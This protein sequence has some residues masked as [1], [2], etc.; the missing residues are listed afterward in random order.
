MDEEKLFSYLKRICTALET[1]TDYIHSSEKTSASEMEPSHIEEVNIDREY[2]DTIPVQPISDATLLKIFLH[3][4]SIQVKKVGGSRPYDKIFDNISDFIGER[5]DSVKPLLD[6]IKSNMAKES[7]FTLS[8]K[9]ETQN[10]R[11]SICQLGNSLYSYAMLKS[12]IYKKS[13]HF[14]IIAKP[15]SKPEFQNLYSGGWME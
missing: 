14:M 10:A 8:I 4:K 1:I 13:P 2:E 15:S 6:R 3:E 7:S 5:Y 11:S 12:Y 9:E